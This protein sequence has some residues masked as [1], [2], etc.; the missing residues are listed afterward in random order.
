VIPIEQAA[1]GVAELAERARAHERIRL[2]AADGE[3]VVMMSQGDLDQALQDATDLAEA[4]TILAAPDPTPLSN[5]AALAWL[6]EV[7]TSG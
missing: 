6:D 2:V 3:V 4:R 1:P 7:I 5:D